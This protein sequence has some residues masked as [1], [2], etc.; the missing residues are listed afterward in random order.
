MMAAVSSA[1]EESPLRTR[2]RAAAGLSEET[3]A[4][5]FV[6]S[7]ETGAISVAY[8]GKL[9]RY[10]EHVPR[11]VLRWLRFAMPDQRTQHPTFSAWM[12]NRFVRQW[13]QFAHQAKERSE[14]ASH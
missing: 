4:V 10:T 7:E 13:N 9:N 6:V 14:H 3:D 8:N 11:K 2:H 12:K 5:I 1:T